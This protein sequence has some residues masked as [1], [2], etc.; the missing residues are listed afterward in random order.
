MVLHHPSTHPHPPKA[1]HYINLLQVGAT[2]ALSQHPSQQGARHVACDVLQVE[3][4][5]LN[6]TALVSKPKWDFL[7]T[8]RRISQRRILS[9]LWMRGSSHQGD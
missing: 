6:M 9:P 8:Y 3:Q 2:A 1:F 4:L 5:C 7:N